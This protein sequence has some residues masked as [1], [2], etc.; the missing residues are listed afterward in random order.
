VPTLAEAGAGNFDFP[1]WYGI[2]VPADTPSGVVAKLANDIGRVLTRSDVREWIAEHG[3]EPMIMTQP[4]FV[5]FVESESKVAAR[6]MEAAS[7]KP[8]QSTVT[9]STGGFGH[10][11]VDRHAADITRPRWF[12]HV[13]GRDWCR[14]V[15]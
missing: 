7:F 3:G 12:T 11:I 2:W 5:R 15:Q 1:I 4:E 8:H 10:L 13:C 9:A 14:S 6:L